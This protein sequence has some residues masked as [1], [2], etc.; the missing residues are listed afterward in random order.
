[1]VRRGTASLISPMSVMGNGKTMTVEAQSTLAGGQPGRVSTVAD[2]CVVEGR[3][4]LRRKCGSPLVEHGLGP[5]SLVC[6][7]CNTYRRIG[8][9]EPSV[10]REVA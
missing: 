3:F 5:R 7:T 8:S 4:C 10:D 1:M 6:P 2:V 9:W